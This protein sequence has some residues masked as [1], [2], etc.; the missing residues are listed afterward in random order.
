MYSIVSSSWK[1]LAFPQFLALASDRR[2]G[3]VEFDCFSFD[4]SLLGGVLT[5]S[6]YFNCPLAFLMPLCMLSA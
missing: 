4:S 1:R 5:P 2:M 6:I 3:N